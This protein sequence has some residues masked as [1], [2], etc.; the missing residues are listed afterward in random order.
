MA[1]FVQIRFVAIIVA[2]GFLW[3]AG[4]GTHTQQGRTKTGPPDATVNGL[5]GASASK[6]PKLGDSFVEELA[7]DV[8]LEMVYI[9]GGTFWMGSPENEPGRDDSEG[10]RHEVKLSP[11]YMGKFE[12]TATLVWQWLEDWKELRRRAAGEKPRRELSGTAE[13][14]ATLIKAEYPYCPITTDYH[15]QDQPVITMT[16]YGAQQFCQWLSVRTGR[17]YRL[18]T[19]AEWE[20]ACRAGTQTAF[21]FGDDPKKLE[22]FAWFGEDLAVHPV[23]QKKPNP[24]GLYDMYGNVAEYVLDGWAENYRPYA[25]K[26][27]VDV[28]DVH[29]DLHWAV[30]RGGSIKSKPEE[31][32]SASRERMLQWYEINDDGVMFDGIS[33]P[34]TQVTGFRVVCPVR[35]EEDGRARCVPKPDDR[36]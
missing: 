8:K 31:M 1:R 7:P 15:N 3:A 18:P 5:E 9:P 11:F 20:Y 29:R 35:K 14:A 21:S 34:G 24:W 25:G 27:S 6:S 10:P 30:T 32:R 36:R 33:V 19:E 23:G 17:H 12:V 16:A 26:V 13:R 4:C 28:W 22:E 2:G